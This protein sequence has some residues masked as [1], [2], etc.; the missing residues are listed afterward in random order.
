MVKFNSELLGGRLGREYRTCGYMLQIYCQNHHKQHDKNSEGLCE[1]CQTQLSYT[2]TKLDRCPYGQAKP[3]CGDCPIHC[4]KPA[5]REFIR[6]IMRFSG[7][8]MLFSHPIIALH[9]LIA[10]RKAPSKPSMQSN[11]KLRERGK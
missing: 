2:E 8:R 6:E 5:E 7:P 4:Y 10:K 9:H 11:R 3:I 1:Q